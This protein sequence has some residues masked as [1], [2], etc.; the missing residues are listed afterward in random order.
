M[1]AAGKTVELFTVVPRPLN[2]VYDQMLKPAEVHLG[3]LDRITV[4]SGR[5]DDGSYGIIIERRYLPTWAIIVAFIPGLLFGFLGLLLLLV[6]TIEECTFR[7]TDAREGGTLLQ[8]SGK[9]NS[10]YL[11][12]LG[13]VIDLNYMSNPSLS[14]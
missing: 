1:A 9:L 4:S 14:R 8:I 6:R 3:A 5:L 2:E 7:L 12:F 11:L 10:K 13:H